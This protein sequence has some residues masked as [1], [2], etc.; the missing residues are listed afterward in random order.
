MEM[1]KLTIRIPK[2]EISFLRKYAHHNGLTISDV[3]VRYVERLKLLQN[4]SIHPDV[5]RFTG[6]I[7]H[8]VDVNKLHH[9]HLLEKHQ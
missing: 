9:S 7:P 2:S 4:Q 6:I 3:I 8:D 1:D 5:K